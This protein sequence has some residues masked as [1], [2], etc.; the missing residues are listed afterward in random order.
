MGNANYI[1]RVGGL[2]LAL[3][4]GMAVGAA[5][6][7]AWATGS[8]STNSSASAANTSPGPTATRGS[9]RAARSAQSSSGAQAAADRMTQN[10]IAAIR[11]QFAER[12]QS[13]ST[14]EA[15]AI[16]Q[17]QTNA[18]IAQNKMATELFSQGV[19]LAN[20]DLNAIN[21]IIKGNA[22]QAASMGQDIAGF[23]S[24]LAGGG[25]MYLNLGKT[26]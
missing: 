22:A 12:G 4:V 15:D 17:V 10:Q 5:P 16:Q 13:G 25:N 24:A 2:A 20:M 6:G 14:S 7:A 26:G 19:S 8:E 23:A 18:L 1:G 3:G 21:D 9:G 11:S